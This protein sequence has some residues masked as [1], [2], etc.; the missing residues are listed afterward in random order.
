[1]FFSRK[2]I[3]VYGIAPLAAAFFLFVGVKV[4]LWSPFFPI[5][6][7]AGVKSMVKL[8]LTVLLER[9]FR[10]SNGDLAL[11]KIGNAV[12]IVDSK[13]SEGVKALFEKFPPPA[14]V[15]F[16]A[17]GWRTRV[18]TLRTFVSNVLPEKSSLPQSPE[19]I[20]ALELLGNNAS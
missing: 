4:Y 8:G 10:F 15:I 13:D 5:V 3:L 20:R 17:S 16:P 19:P 11:K 6:E 18:E 14:E 12:M 7:I 1:M 9:P 2:K